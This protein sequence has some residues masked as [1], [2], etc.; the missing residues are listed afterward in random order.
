MWGHVVLPDKP[1][2][3]ADTG[4]GPAR[5]RGKGKQHEYLCQ[6]CAERIYGLK[7]PSIVEEDQ[8]RLF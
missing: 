3:Q 1:R 6:G 8:E 5:K 4:H 7:P 2:L